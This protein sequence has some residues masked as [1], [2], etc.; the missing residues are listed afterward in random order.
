MLHEQFILHDCYIFFRIKRCTTRCFSCKFYRFVEEL[1]AYTETIQSFMMQ[2]KYSMIFNNVQYIILHFT[3]LS[4]IT[5]ILLTLNLLNFLNGK[6]PPSIFG[7]VQYNIRDIKVNEDDQPTEQG[8]VRMHGCA[9]WPDYILMAK[10][11][12]FCHQQDKG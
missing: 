8:L 11:N 12:Q 7:L 9:G 10:V 6:Y 4:D 2:I 1:C 3:R 5:F